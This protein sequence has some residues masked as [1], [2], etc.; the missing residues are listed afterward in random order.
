[1]SG[2]KDG[3]GQRPTRR[4]RPEL[5]GANLAGEG[6]RDSG[7]DPA[8]PGGSDRSGGR[9]DRLDAGGRAIG[10]VHSPGTHQS[11]EPPVSAV[12]TSS[13]EA[14]LSGPADIAE[15]SGPTRAT[16]TDD[17][18]AVLMSAA[19]MRT[20]LGSGTARP[21]SSFVTDFVNYDDQW[22]LLTD[23]GWLRIDDHE[24]LAVLDQPR[25]WIKD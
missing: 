5:N 13:A 8:Y 24:L 9:S 19:A 1:M 25:R 16:A 18:G 22:W 23:Q 15:R 11:A 3:A 4:G 20:A 17:P 14:P 12:D 2:R 10:I 6:P 21:L 7:R